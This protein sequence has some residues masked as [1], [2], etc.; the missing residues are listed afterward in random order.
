VGLGAL[1]NTAGGAVRG[2]RFPLL[3]V[4][5]AAFVAG[6]T[7]TSGTGGPTAAIFGGDL[8]RPNPGAE[9]I[10]S[11]EHSQIV[12]A[13]GGIYRD[14][15]LEQALVPIV[16][17]IVA[18]SERPEQPYRITILNAP[19]VNA[20]ALP[21]GYLYVTRGLLALANDSSEVAAV[22]A[23]EMAHVVANHAVQ[24]QNKVRDAQIVS[25][26]VSDVDPDSGQ[27]ALASSQRTLAS[28]S[29][30]QELEADAMGV[31]TIG[32]AGYDPF[33]AARFLSTMATYS[34]YRASLT[35]RDKRPD[36][37]S[38]HPTTP[39]RV[40]FAE[41]AARQFGAPG[42]GAVDRERYL[43]G[44][45]GMVFGD[46]PSQ[47]F[48]RE[49]AFVHPKLGIGFTVPEGFIIDNT[50]DAVLAT[51]VDGTALRFDAVGLA[52]GTDLAEYLRSG[53][54][55]GLDA[56]TVSSF[57]VNGL[58]AA[59]AEAQ[60]K[61]WF[62]QIAVIQAGGAATYRFIFANEARSDPFRAA[63]R[64]T[65]DSFRTLTEREIA[66]LSS[67]RIRLVEAGPGDSEASLVRRMKGVDRP[68]E[69]FRAINGLSAGGSVQSGLVYKIVT[70][71]T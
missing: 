48:V 32:K 5:A 47:G 61:G 15:K 25:Q 18:A 9:R 54:V 70:D 41:R 40:D 62:F 39:Q 50:S 1:K 64:A 24:R 27:L 33:A 67:L 38:S 17:R 55:N 36:F 53:W 7:A 13:Y 2:W 16:S 14:P 26:A 31:K 59:S 12:A 44:I 56:T 34:D 69:L 30:Q 63:A 37:L 45:D 60:A 8:E 22:L 21:G 51:G 3:A 43:A 10:D 23:H 71:E 57:S 20:F 49:R 42:V 46:D 52:Q 4:I 6:C 28:F 29:Q 66:A 19:A 68:R 11:E 65:V 35:M 58:Q